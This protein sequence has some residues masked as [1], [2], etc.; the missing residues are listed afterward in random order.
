MNSPS[1]VH[2]TI[3]GSVGI[4]GGILLWISTHLGTAFYALLLLI[5]LNVVA[6]MWERDLLKSVNKWLKII[7][8]TAIPFVTPLLASTQGLGWTDGDSKTLVI[9]VFAALLASTIP[10]LLVFGTKLMTALKIPQAEQ[11]VIESAASSAAQN[12]IANLKQQIADLQKAQNTNAGGGPTG[13]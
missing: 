2:N 11:K 6:A 12:E 3:G 10:D 1:K 8:G 7:M 13:A 4:L 9:L 5:F